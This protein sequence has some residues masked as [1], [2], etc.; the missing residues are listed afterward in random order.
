MREGDRIMPFIRGSAYV[1]AV[2]TLVFED[3]DP[4]RNGI[5]APAGLG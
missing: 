3:Q 5:P 4:F 1:T 2:S